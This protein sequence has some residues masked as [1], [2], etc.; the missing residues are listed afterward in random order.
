MSPR[1]QTDLDR[2]ISTSHKRFV[3]AMEERM[4]TV[5]EETKS[6]YFVILTKLVDKLEAP[7]KPLKEILQE[8]MAEAMTEVLQMIQA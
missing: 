2:Q 6:S 1:T 3:K 4:G 5:S 8:M 7:E